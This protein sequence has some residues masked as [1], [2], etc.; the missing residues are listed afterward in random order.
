[1]KNPFITLTLIGNNK[2]KCR[3]N[4]THI[5]SYRQKQYSDSK[6]KYT[7]ILLAGGNALSREVNETPEEIDDMISQFY[8]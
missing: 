6:G 8:N 7:Y 4:I 3:I 1:M 2:V 5:M